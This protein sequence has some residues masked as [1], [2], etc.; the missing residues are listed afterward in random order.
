MP[1]TKANWTVVHFAKDC[2]AMFEAAR[3]RPPSLE[4]MFMSP[5]GSID[6]YR[7]ANGRGLIGRGERVILNMVVAKQQRK[8]PLALRPMPHGSRV[9]ERP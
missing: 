5:H 9:R 7:R 6:V 8:Q 2:S 3:N 4:F 1:E